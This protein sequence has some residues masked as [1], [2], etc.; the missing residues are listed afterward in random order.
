M[1]RSTL[2]RRAG[3]LV[4]LGNLVGDARVADLRL[5]ADDALRERGRGGQERAG[6]LLGGEAADL[7]QR[8]RDCAPLPK[9]SGGSR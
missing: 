6:D 5:G 1:T 2:S 3:E 9:G 8:Q 7:A 4:R